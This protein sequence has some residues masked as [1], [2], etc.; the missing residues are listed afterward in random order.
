MKNST[1]L[2]PKLISENMYFLFLK[3]KNQI[4]VYLY[5]VK[6]KLLHRISKI[7]SF[8]YYL[9][10]MKYN[11]KLCP[12]YINGKGFISKNI[13]AFSSISFTLV[14]ATNYKGHLLKRL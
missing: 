11:V 2:R 9:K 12:N 5:V 1:I 14:A 3:K 4:E 7:R 13:S 10:N 8:Y 6:G